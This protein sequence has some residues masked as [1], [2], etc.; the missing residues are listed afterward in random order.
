MELYQAAQFGNVTEPLLAA[1]NLTAIMAVYDIDL[2]SSLNLHEL[3]HPTVGFNNIVLPVKPYNSISEFN[4]MAKT[5]KKNQIPT[6]PTNN[7]F[8]N[9]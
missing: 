7:V 6:T 3:Q 8:R 9:A 2:D 1:L 5:S 4:K